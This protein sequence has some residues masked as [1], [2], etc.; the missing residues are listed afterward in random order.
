MIETTASPFRYQLWLS[1]LQS[2]YLWKFTSKMKT[3]V[4]YKFSISCPEHS[5]MVVLIVIQSLPRHLAI[6]QLQATQ[7]RILPYQ[8][9]GIESASLP[10]KWSISMRWLDQRTLDISVEERIL[11]SLRDVERCLRITERTRAPVLAKSNVSL[12]TRTNTKGGKEKRGWQ[13][14]FEERA[15]GMGREAFRVKIAE[16]ASRRGGG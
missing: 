2:T 11:C 7:S 14:L 5:N 12:A 16:I 8:R 6:L 15:A 1:Q 9:S 13:A 4:Q 10:V 3:N